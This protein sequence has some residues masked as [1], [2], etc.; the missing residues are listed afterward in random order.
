MERQTNNKNKK[1]DSFKQGGQ[2]KKGSDSHRPTSKDG[3]TQCKDEMD[4]NN[5]DG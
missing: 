4:G 2:M 5:C 1:S 3:T